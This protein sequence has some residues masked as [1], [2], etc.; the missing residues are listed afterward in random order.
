MLQATNLLPS[1]WQRY[2]P[3]QPHMS[4]R[5]PL[6]LAQGQAGAKRASYEARW[7]FFVS[8]HTEAPVRYADVPWHL[9]AQAEGAAGTEELQHVVLYGEAGPVGS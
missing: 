4:A 3:A 9:P 8:K 2:P 5:P 1:H 7:Q 6:P